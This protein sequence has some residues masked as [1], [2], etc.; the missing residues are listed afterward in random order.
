MTK[1]YEPI[2]AQQVI[3]YPLRQRKNKVQHQNFGQPCA[4][5][6]SFA[7]FA[8][9]LPHILAGDDVR[10]VVD[11]IVKAHQR[12][13]PVIF[14]FGAHV[15]KCGLSLFVIELIKRGIISAVA[16]NGAGVIHDFEIALIGE[17]SEDVA[18]GLQTGSFGMAEE[19]AKYIN[20]AINE[21]AARNCG[22]GKAI[23]ETI[24]SMDLPFRQYSILAHAVQANIPVTV[25]IAIGDDITHMHPS[26]DGATLGKTSMA[27]FRLLTS[28]VADLGDGGVYINAGSAVILPEVFLKALTLARNLGHDVT[29]FVTVN[30]DQIQHYRPTQNVVQRPATLGGK[31]YALTGHHEIM[32][33]LV[34]QMIIEELAV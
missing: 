1:H 12:A 25:H 19:T 6:A 31:G 3:T 16:M 10:A 13:R 30:L 32:I 5:N 33:P 2:N 28:V 24:L 8:N 15:I 9:A 17:T 11:A 29:D 34:T 22:L 18:E 27:D 4:P 21:G 26:A 23:G 14:A 7:A 20:G